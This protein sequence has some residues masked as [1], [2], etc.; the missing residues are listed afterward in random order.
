MEGSFGVRNS[1]GGKGEGVR[2]LGFSDE[3]SVE[4]AETA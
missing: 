4:K 1:E 3:G 2:R